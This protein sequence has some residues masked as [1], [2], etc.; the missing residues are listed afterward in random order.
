MA[1]VENSGSLSTFEGAPGI[2]LLMGPNEHEHTA[3]GAWQ[4][5]R[6]RGWGGG[7]WQ[8]GG[9]AHLQL[10]N[11]HTPV[12]LARPPLKSSFAANI[13]Y[14]HKYGPENMSHCLEKCIAEWQVQYAVN[15]SI[16]LWVKVSRTS[17]LPTIKRT[18]LPLKCQACFEA[19]QTQQTTCSLTSTLPSLQ[20]M[21]CFRHRDSV[22]SH[23]NLKV[24]L[25]E[26]L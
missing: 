11:W 22:P 10:G 12:G 15:I 19:N 1:Q 23:V 17:D 9:G 4:D 2:I 20:I 5:I 16:C 13:T 21:Y 3:G 18:Q 8:D 25:H 14:A 24:Y 26:L 6:H 7:G